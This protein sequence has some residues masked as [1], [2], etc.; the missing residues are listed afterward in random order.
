MKT[1]ITA[2]GS[3][4]LQSN[5]V[6]DTYHSTH[7]AAN[8]AEIVYITHGLKFCFDTCQGPINLLEIGFGTGLN[9]LLT[10][11][12]ATRC[13]RK[14]TY[15]TL[16]PFPID[17]E[18][19][20]SLNYGDIYNEFPLLFSNIHESPWNRPVEITPYFTLIK[21]DTTLQEVDFGCSMFQLVYFDAFGPDKQPEVWTDDLFAK[22]AAQMPEQGILT[23]YSTKGDVKRALK[24]CGFLIEKLPGPVGKR[25]VL[26]AVLKRG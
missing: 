26:R 4:T 1:L 6:D 11:I 8:E 12:E 21:L 7:G 13:Q 25:E 5:R 22:V 10:A 24:R 20:R 23:T 9:A 19:I 16:E 17:A 14:V 18:T 2:D 3:H 15:Y